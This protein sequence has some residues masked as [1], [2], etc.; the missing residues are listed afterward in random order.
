[1]AAASRGRPLLP[2]GDR[3]LA[4]GTLIAVVDA[5]D[6]WPV[7]TTYRVYRDDG[8]MVVVLREH[9]LTHIMEEYRVARGWVRLIDEA[10]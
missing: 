1:M 10:R 4:P 7:H 3:P 8:A 6:G 5:Y 2:V 9:P